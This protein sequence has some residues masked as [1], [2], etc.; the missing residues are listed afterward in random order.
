M[1][2]VKS[3]LKS[4]VTVLTAFGLEHMYEKFIFL[5]H[6]DINHNSNLS[7]PNTN[8]SVHLLTVLV[9]S[10][11]GQK[12]DRDFLPSSYRKVNMRNVHKV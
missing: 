2:L 1:L 7:R 11:S 4:V 9:T 8:Y 5:S 12:T 10:S 6:F 3:V